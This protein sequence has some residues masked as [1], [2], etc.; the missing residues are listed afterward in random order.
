M[1]RPTGT[2]RTTEAVDAG[3]VEKML[4]A[5]VGFQ[6]AFS[7]L[8]GKAKLSQNKTAVDVAGVIGGLEERGDSASMAV[9]ALMQRYAKP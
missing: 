8:E 1:F 9:A 7:T 5:I 6:L 3:Q 2:N 4:S